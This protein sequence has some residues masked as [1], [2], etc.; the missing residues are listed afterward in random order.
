MGTAGALAGLRRLVATGVV[1]ATFGSALAANW[2]NPHTGMSFAPVIVITPG[3][4]IIV[5]LCSVNVCTTVDGLTT[6]ANATFTSTATATSTT[7]V[8]AN[9]SRTT[10]TN[11]PVTSTLSN[12]VVSP[13]FSIT[14]GRFTVFA[15][16]SNLTLLSL[17]SGQV[18]Y[19]QTVTTN[20]G[21]RCS[22]DTV[23]T[24]VATSAN[25]T[26]TIKATATPQNCDGICPTQTSTLTLNVPLP[27]STSTNTST[28]PGVVPPPTSTNPVK[29]PDA[30][31]VAAAPGALTAPEAQDAIAKCGIQVPNCVA[32]ALDAYANHLE[33]IAASLPPSMR[34]LPQIFH[35]AARK[36]REARTPAAAVRAITTALAQV[37][38]SITL[39]R[40]VDADTRTLGRTV[41]AQS[42]DVLQ[43][44]QVALS[45]VSGL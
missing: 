31:L 24:F 12:I 26:V 11:I 45:R 32:D 25:G 35:E 14:T 34:K 7:T 29:G 6:T 5:K 9:G 23:F 2:I 21:T 20:C 44:A 13:T 4:P 37:K 42:I 41:G 18:S 36:V 40:A 8:G 28:T 17:T 33:Q 15:T 27:T 39:I 1:L 22:F 19:T 38:A 30:T 3:S 43:S 16:A 10:T